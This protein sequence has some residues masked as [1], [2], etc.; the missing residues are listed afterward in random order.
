MAVACMIVAMGWWRWRSR[1]WLLIAVK[2]VM[3]VVEFWWRLRDCGVGL[4]ESAVCGS[5]RRYGV[6]GLVTAMMLVSRWCLGRR[7]QIASWVSEYAVPADAA[8]LAVSV[9]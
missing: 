4:V 8:T 5:L 6:G 7:F 1:R 2:A 9:V 3:A